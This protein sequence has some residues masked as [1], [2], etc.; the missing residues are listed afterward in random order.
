M[1]LTEVEAG[2]TSEVEFS[3]GEPQDSAEVKVVMEVMVDLGA[4]VVA[5]A[6]QVGTVVLAWKEAIEADQEGST[7]AVVEDQ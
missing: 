3:M 5:K 7:E 2:W 1:A 4:M 6:G